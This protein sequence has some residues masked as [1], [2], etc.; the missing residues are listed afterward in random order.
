MQTEG[1][2]Y[3]EDIFLLNLIMNLYLLKLTGK[4]L[5]YKTGFFKVFAGSL[6]GA[7]G[8]CA[9]LCIP[10]VAYGWR[11]L[12]GMLPIGVCMIRLSLGIKGRKELG[13][14]AGWLFTFAFLLGGFIIFLK[15]KL[16]FLHQYKD[17][18]FWVAG[19]GFIGYELLRKGLEISLRRKEAVFKKVRLAADMG[20]MEVTALVD[21]GNGLIDP[22][23][24]KPVAVLEEESW[25]KMTGWMRPE[26]YHVI[27]FHSIGK[28]HGLLGGYEV[29]LMEVEDEIGVR[30]YN[31]V[32]IAVFKGK[33]S[34]TGGYQMILP[35]ELSI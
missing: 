11:L 30:Q 19:M 6:L 22:V 5:K 14:A 13:Y 31:N 7:A 24:Q 9:V 26:K 27:P 34:K 20:D 4:V 12:F 33:L 17:T 32:I 25:Q 21:T 15:G 8:Y 10:D 2:I 29:G 28:E 1:N 18:L 23:S 16:P 3:L 35:P